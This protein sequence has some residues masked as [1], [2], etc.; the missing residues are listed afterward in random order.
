[1]NLD[2]NF[3]HPNRDLFPETLLTQMLGNTVFTSSRKL[4]E[5][6]GK[7]HDDVLRAIR[8]LLA[9]L[10]EPGFADANFIAMTYQQKVGVTPTKAAA[11]SAKLRSKSTHRSGAATREMPMYLLTEEGFAILAMGFT[12][13]EALAWKLKFLAAFRDMERQLHARTA[14]E[15]SALFHL[16]PRWRVI[17]DNP[18]LRNSQMAQLT[19]HKSPSSITANR[20]RM[21]QVGLA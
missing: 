21:R 4:A 12:G 3:V 17:R 8:K 9:D 15:S 18:G 13:R 19:G 2:G 16:R 11:Y 10:P 20:R 1:M 14:R 5:H 6:F 7:R